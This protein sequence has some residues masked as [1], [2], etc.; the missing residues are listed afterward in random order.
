MKKGSGGRITSLTLEKKGGWEGGRE[1]EGVAR[2]CDG[3]RCGSGSGGIRRAD[4]GGPANWREAESRV[5]QRR[6]VAAAPLLIAPGAAAGG[7]WIQR[8]WRR[9]WRRQLPSDPRQRILDC[10][11]YAG[12][13]GTRQP[14][15]S[16]GAP[17]PR[18]RHQRGRPP[19]PRLCSVPAQEVSALCP[20]PGALSA[21]A[22][23]A[24]PRFLPSFL[25]HSA[26]AAAAV[27]VA[28]AQACI[29]PGRGLLCVR[30]AVCA[31]A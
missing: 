1:R 4:G 2:R 13:M 15:P 26:R 19:A 31:A 28:A 30:S 3:K 27:A 6:A 14:L 7:G 12:D 20:Q 23:P 24:P 22:G 17:L 8:P 5:S 11:P 16:L 29:R 10:S 9:L 25:C 18:P 21:A